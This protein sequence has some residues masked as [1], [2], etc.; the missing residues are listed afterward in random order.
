MRTSTNKPTYLTDSRPDDSSA[1]ATMSPWIV[2]DPFIEP[3]QRAPGPGVAGTILATG[4][5]RRVTRTG[6][7]VR[8][9]RSRIAGQ[10]AL[11]L[12]ISICSMNQSYDGQVSRSEWAS[13]SRDVARIWR[14]VPATMKRCPKSTV[15]R[16][17]AF[18]IAGATGCATVPET[19]WNV[20]EVEGL[21]DEVVCSG[22]CAE[23]WERAKEWVK[24]HSGYPYPADVTAKPDRIEASR[25]PIHNC[26]S[27]SQTRRKSLCPELPLAS[28]PLGFGDPVGF[29]GAVRIG[30]IF[31]D[32]GPHWTFL[33]LRQAM[34]SGSSR[35]RLVQRCHARGG[36]R[37]CDVPTL[38]ENR[39]DRFRRFVRTGEHLSH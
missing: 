20:P 9:T 8:A 28:E 1:G 34:E 19:A 36:S 11:N 14:A 17:A 39:Q 23:E 38:R 2:T 30:Q 31:A 16:I 25:V 21:E 24:K 7:R 15:T 32:G 10:V 27:V 12:E 18:A 37:A 13:A 26:E 4:S 35:V 22:T 6:F 29:D 3:S 5:P 33:V